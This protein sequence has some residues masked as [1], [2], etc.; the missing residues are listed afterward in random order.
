MNP[1]TTDAAW[2][3]DGLPVAPTTGR[4]RPVGIHDVHITG[5]LWADMQTLNASVVIDHAERWMEKVGWIGNFDAA[6]EGRLPGD[7]RGR[8]F[9]DSD[10]YK[11]MEA[12]AWEVGRTGNPDLEQ[13]FTA[14][15]ER[16]APVQEEDG[17]LNTK[18]GRPG[19]S[20]RYSDFEWG[21]ELYCFG[22]LIQ[23]GIAR[24][25]THGRDAFVD[26]TIRAA[27]HVC[28]V[29]GPGGI[30]MVDGHPEIETALAE[31]GRLT[32]EDRYLDQASLFLERRG[33]GLLG[34]ID[35]GQEYFQDDVPVRDAEVLRGHAVRALY[36][37]SGAVDV[38]TER[39][40]EDLLDAVERQLAR[41]VARRTYL[42][43]G[44]GAH[45]EGESFGQ[46]YE[47][48]SDRAYSETCA[49]VAAVQ[50][51][52]RLLLSTGA[53][54]QADLV[55]RVLHN[56]LSAS[57]AEDGRSFF[58]TNTLHQR[59][60]GTKPDLDAP[61][62]RASS[63][64]RAPWFAVSCC[65]TNVARTIASLGAY[66]ATVDSGGLQL[67]QYA[68]ARIRTRLPNG[69]AVGL[70]VETD[71]PEQGRI[72]VTVVET[73]DEPWTLSMRVPGWAGGATVTARAHTETAPAGYAEVRGPWIVGDV[74]D[75]DLPLRARWTRPHPE[76]DALR[77]QVAVE[78]G[79]V[80]YCLESVDLGDDIAT[81]EV[82]VDAPP[83]DGDGEVRV[84]VRR[85]R[86]VEAGWPYQS[87]RPVMQETSE[88]E[89]VRVIPYRT[90]GNRGPSTMR[91]WIPVA[92][93]E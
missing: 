55:E 50:L 19:Q 60:P 15:T 58:Y 14:L 75:L 92:L 40:D 51:A 21:H 78:R 83:V 69:Q 25:R 1:T 81:A 34:E 5:G 89:L 91:V 24:A 80:V 27:D 36:L 48:P 13:R 59:E 7:R 42:T 23:A 45:H 93:A 66:M 39:D 76:I 88:P 43:G 46:D 12:M 28:D 63:S 10:V 82:L 38:A 33:R 11:L 37:S 72:R 2:H 77:R 87:G 70:D 86:R 61:S 31:L 47:L 9:S 44:M 68:S 84:R 56:V 17:Y 22:H 4:L 49:G 85:G 64:L 30:E 90:W 35:F 65:P 71:Y 57:L 8:E 67:H 6:R 16:I 62:P 18:F 52:H 29:F 20:P 32:G 41:T 3:R 54:E 74:V 26:V 53:R 73:P 79:P